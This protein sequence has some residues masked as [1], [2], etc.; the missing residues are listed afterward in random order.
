MNL[1][2]KQLTQEYHKLFSGKFNCGNNRLNIFFNGM[3]SL[4]PGIGI[5][6]VLL[7]DDNLHLIGYYNI[8]SGV[9]INPNNPGER[10][11]GSIHINCFAIDIQYQG[12]LQDTKPDGTIIKLS[13]LFLMD[14]VNRILN[15]RNIIGFSF[16]TLSSTKEGYNLYKRA[17]FEKIESDMLIS[18]KNMECQSIPMYLPLDMY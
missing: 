13:D 17:D 11:G 5:T 6:Y 12:L 7:S 15:I 8:T 16:I 4:D 10:I 18:E 9:I 1:N 2:V 14:C 3:E